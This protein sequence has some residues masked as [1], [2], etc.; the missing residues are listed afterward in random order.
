ME[1]TRS[2]RIVSITLGAIAGVAIGVS[3]LDILGLLPGW[4]TKLTPF[5]VGIRLL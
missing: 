5:F 3:L 4:A 2:D 1:G